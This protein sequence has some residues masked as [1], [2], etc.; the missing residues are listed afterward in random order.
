MYNYVFHI[1][2]VECSQTRAISNNISLLP[3]E[4][5]NYSPPNT[6]NRD[7]NISTLWCPETDMLPS[8]LLTFVEPVYLLYVVGSFYDNDFSITYENSF[9]ENVTYT[10]MDGIYVSARLA[11]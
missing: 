4:N 6:H 3:T 9:G 1:F 2:S 11:S 8:V 10:K 7:R 5:I